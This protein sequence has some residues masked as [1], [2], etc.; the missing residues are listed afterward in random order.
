VDFVFLPGILRVVAAFCL[1]ESV[2]SMLVQT[3][4]KNCKGNEERLGEEV[5][6]MLTSFTGLCTHFPLIIW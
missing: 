3:D 4:G 5:A 1:G 6:E 2:K